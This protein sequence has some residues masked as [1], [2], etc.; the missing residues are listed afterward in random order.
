ML[1]GLTGLQRRTEVEALSGPGLPLRGLATAGGGR[2]QELKGAQSLPTMLATWQPADPPLWLLGLALALP[3][4]PSWAL[5]PA[6]APRSAHLS[7][8]GPRPTLPGQLKAESLYPPA[9]AQRGEK[10]LKTWVSI[11]AV[12]LCGLGQVTFRLWA[13]FPRWLNIAQMVLSILG[14]FKP[15]DNSTS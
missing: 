15:S 12:P 10:S 7:W 13:M 9:G 1:S 5:R 11:A 8:A 3:P 6:L 14:V 4:H 2:R